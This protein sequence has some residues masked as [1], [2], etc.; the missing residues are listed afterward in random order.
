MAVSISQENLKKNVFL[1]VDNQSLKISS[2][3]SESRNNSLGS[4]N[5][6]NGTP[7][8]KLPPVNTN[9]NN[10]D[11]NNMS[12]NNN[13]GNNFW[14]KSATSQYSKGSQGLKR[15]ENFC[16]ELQNKVSYFLSNYNIILLLYIY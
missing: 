8:K 11:S 15:M 9:N 12:S 3:K 10:G 13:D 7:K 2:I 1:K 14:N 5:S 16:E 4:L 6:L